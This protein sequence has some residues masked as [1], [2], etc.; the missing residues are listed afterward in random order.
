[1]KQGRIKGVK[2]RMITPNVLNLAD[3]SPQSLYLNGQQDSFS[4]IDPNEWF[5]FKVDDEDEFGPI[6]SAH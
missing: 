4:F 2:Q 5:N 6:F 1:M 3:F